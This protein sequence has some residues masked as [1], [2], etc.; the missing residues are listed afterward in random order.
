M[1]TLHT[2]FFRGVQLLAAASAAM[3]AGGCLT[4]SDVQAIAQGQVISFVNALI[5][6]VTSDAL[7][8]ALA[9]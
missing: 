1:S 2:R 3:L 6:T 7:H 5:T 8:A 4:P 9:G